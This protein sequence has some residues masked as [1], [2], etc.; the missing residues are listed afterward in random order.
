[1]KSDCIVHS[2]EDF[3]YKLTKMLPKAPLGK[4]LSNQRPSYHSLFTYYFSIP[5]KKEVSQVMDP[6]K[7]G[8]GGG[9][10]KFAA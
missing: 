1:M 8:G 2:F 6:P 3:C 4:Y 10:V 9:G 5:F 7:G